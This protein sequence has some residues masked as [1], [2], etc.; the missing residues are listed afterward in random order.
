MVQYLQASY[1]V[2]T[3]RACDVVGKIRS[4][5]YYR[6]VADPQTALR[7]RLRDLTNTRVGYGYRRLHILMQWEG[8][9]VNQQRDL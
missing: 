2:S 3:R 4:S 1:E 7:V 8:W 9:R 6:S 5:H